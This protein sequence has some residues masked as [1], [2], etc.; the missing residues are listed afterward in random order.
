MDFTFD[1]LKSLV[2]RLK[3]SGYAFGTVRDIAVDRTRN[4]GRFIIL[5]HDV[6][7][8][9]QNAL[10]CATM[11]TKMGISGTYY[12]RIT[13]GS[14]DSRIIREISSLGHE[15]GYHYEDLSLAARKSGMLS[16]L[17]RGSSSESLSREAYDS[18]AENLEKMRL[19]APVVTACM[20]GSPMSRYDSRLLW[21]FFD[22]R[23]LGI[24]CEPYFDIDLNDTLYLSDTG[25]RW[26]GR[27]VSVRDRL[28]SREEGYYADWVRKPLRG[29]AMNAGEEAAGMRKRYI[30]RTTEDIIKSVSENNFP[31]RAL[32]TLH[33]QRWSLNMSQWFWELV[34]QKVKNAAKYFLA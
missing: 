7:R 9:P 15:I 4:S 14:F 8:C 24:I 33:P 3:D 22:Y 29:S 23:E 2:G 11:E 10:S 30:Y 5:R 25:R 19:L 13:P 16:G 26:D 28:Y 17:R 27:S 32:I 18:F 1:A 6:D 34:S 31:D 12:F 20:H 21:K